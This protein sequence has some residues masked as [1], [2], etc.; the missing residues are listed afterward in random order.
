LGSNIIR[1][2]KENEFNFCRSWHSTI[3]NIDNKFFALFN[4]D[5]NDDYFINRTII[6]KNL[7][8]DTINRHEIEKLMH[9]L[10]QLSKERKI[11]IYLH[12]DSDKAVLEDYLI[13]K[14][15]NKI[16]EVLG[17]HYLDYSD[18]SIFN[19][20]GG[21]AI[22]SDQ[23]LQILVV[24]SINSLK[25]WVKTYCLCFSIDKNKEKLI[26]QILKKKFNIFKFVYAEINVNGGNKKQIVGC[27]ILFF[28]N[29]CIALYC[30][31]TIKE[32]RHKNIATNIIDFSRKL[33][34]E[35]GYA[36]FGLQTLNSDNLLPFYKKNGFVKIYNNKVYEI[37]DR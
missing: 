24:D 11:N 19:L 2:L 21:A 25:K 33:C 7:V 32:Y 37:C 36:I 4:K 18:A 26:C 27:C 6:N 34:R 31:G 22:Q 13:Y 28:Y 17:L 16:D 23:P 3:L 1:I 10:I 12:I 35:K 29:N 14:N 9:P 20:Y 30:L 5:L 8:F 15:F